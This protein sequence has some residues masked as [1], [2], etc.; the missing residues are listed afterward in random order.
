VKPKLPYQFEA[1]LQWPGSGPACAHA[2]ERPWLMV[3]PPPE[4]GGDP[5]QWS[6]EHLLLEALNGC[7]MA[8]FAAVAA[9]QG[10]AVDDYVSRAHA[11]LDRTPEGVHFTSFRLAVIVRGAPDGEERLRAAMDK[12]RSHCFVAH[13]LRVPV[14]VDLT[15]EAPQREPAA[16]H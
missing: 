2:G 10:L 13:A 16:V 4:F 3:G 1:V 14:E 5:A 8:T 12:A 15:V 11:T 6:P 9:A 7:L